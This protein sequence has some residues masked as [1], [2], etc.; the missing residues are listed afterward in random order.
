MKEK[1]DNQKA[2]SGYT[3]R[4]KVSKKDSLDETMTSKKEGMHSCLQE[5]EK[6]EV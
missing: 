6:T 3:S 1:T 4:K 2:E 5:T